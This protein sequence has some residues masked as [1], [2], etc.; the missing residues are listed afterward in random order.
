M[1]SETTGQNGPL[2]PFANIFF[3]TENFFGIEIDVEPKSGFLATFFL[4]TPLPPFPTHQ[5]PP[6]YWAVTLLSQNIIH[7]E[8]IV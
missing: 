2:S 7:H 6:L 3:E 8:D 5:H 1:P 4:G